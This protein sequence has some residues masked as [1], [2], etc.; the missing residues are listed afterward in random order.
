MDRALADPQVI[1]NLNKGIGMF[2]SPAFQQK[3]IPALVT[4][5]EVI[6]GF[7]APQLLN[8]LLSGH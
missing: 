3:A 1:T 6:T 2:Y 8:G 5:N 4:K 7:P